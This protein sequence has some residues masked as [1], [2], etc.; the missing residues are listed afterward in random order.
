MLRA[1]QMADEFIPK[2]S[3]C[4]L[5]VLLSPLSLCSLA[6]AVHQLVVNDGVLVSQLKYQ[7]LLLGITGLVSQDEGQLLVNYD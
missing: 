2:F 4:V 7:M 6:V 3:K 1:S 5:L